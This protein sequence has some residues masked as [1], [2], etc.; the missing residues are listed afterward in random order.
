MSKIKIYLSFVLM[1]I[2]LTLGLLIYR[3]FNE[4][5]KHEYAEIYTYCFINK[6]ALQGTEVKPAKAFCKCLSEAMYIK[7]LRLKD[8]NKEDAKE[9][10]TECEENE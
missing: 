8:L 7:Q 3:S 4:L 6:V 5:T 1:C 10:I 2:I 9:L